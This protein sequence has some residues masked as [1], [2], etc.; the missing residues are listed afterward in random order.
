MIKAL[1]LPKTLFFFCL[2]LS[3]SAVFAQQDEHCGTD[4]VLQ[5]VIQK[6]P[7]A[8]IQI[9]QNRD[10]VRRY[11][12][13]NVSRDN[14]DTPITIPVVVHVIHSGQKIDSGA[15]IS[16]A[17]I[18][19]Q[20]DVLN[21][22]FNKQDKDTVFGHT[23]F[24]SRIA[25]VQFKF[26]LAMFNPL[27]DA[28]TG[29]T[30]DSFPPMS[31]SGFDNTVKPATQWDPTKYLNIWTDSVPGNVLGYTSPM[32]TPVNWDGVVIDYRY[33]GSKPANH[34]D[35]IYNS[36]P[37][38][39]NVFNL[40]K[41]A[42][43]E[44]GHWLGLYHTFGQDSSDGSHIDGCFGLT[45]Q[46]CD[47]AGD[48]MCDTPPQTG[49]YSGTPSLTANSCHETPTDEKDMWEDYMDYAD[50]NQLSMFTPDQAAEMRAVLNTVRQSIQLST[51]AG[52]CKLVVGL[53]EIAN[54]LQA[55]LFPN[56]TNGMVTLQYLQNN[57][58]PLLLEVMDITGKVLLFKNL[59]VT[60]RNSYS[61]DMAGQPNGLYFVRLQS[62][63]SEKTLKLSLVQ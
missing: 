43:H 30:R 34:F 24:R 35:S 48:G 51:A 38:V 50:D 57:S 52:S 22:C 9:R 26:C 28:T 54:N 15:N 58:Q 46:D 63:F 21:R 10:A 31:Q 23:D 7:S 40:G 47:T 3:V 14:S 36:K 53:D 44:V 59:P 27:G 33:F 4:R 37:P 61:L 29:I 60:T 55:N 62:G 41:T 16:D 17:Q 20:I 2:L 19:S 49:P 32:L 56:P 1:Y 39:K 6:D 13:L 11:I 12:D 25:N 42:V 18:H 5:Q 8:A 45:Q